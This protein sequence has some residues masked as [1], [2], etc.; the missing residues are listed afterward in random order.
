MNEIRK[1]IGEREAPPSETKQIKISRMLRRSL[2]LLIR[3]LDKSDCNT[4]V[5]P[6]DADL[7]ERV[8]VS[9]TIQ[10]RKFKHTSGG[11]IQ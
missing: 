7:N 11:T 4:V 1:L 2:T 10:Q 5:I 9:V 8:V 6:V 3:E